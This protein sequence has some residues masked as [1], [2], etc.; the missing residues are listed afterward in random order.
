MS[1]YHPDKIWS[2]CHNVDSLCDLDLWQ[3]DLKINRYHLH[4]NTNV[5]TKF[6]EP[7]SI[8]CLVIIRTRFGLY[9]KMLTV[10]VT[11]TF[12][13]LI[14]KSKGIIYT[15]TNVCTKCDEP[16]SILCLVITGTRFGLYSNMLMVSVTLTFDRLISLLI[17]IIYT[18]IQM[19][20]QN[21]TNLGQFC[22]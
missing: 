3:I 11:L 2:I 8:L 5:C 14:S 16:R 4:S 10:T 6:D 19:S 9:I 7:R 21:L 17:R 20:V 15:N 13:R 12:E 18:P 1:S 22:V